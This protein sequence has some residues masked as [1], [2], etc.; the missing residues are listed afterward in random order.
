MAKHRGESMTCKEAMKT[1]D[2]IPRPKV[3]VGI[4]YD[5]IG[6]G[7]TFF[8]ACVNGTV[9]YSSEDRNKADAAARRLRHALGMKGGEG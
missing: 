1:Y 2:L 9:I 8:L 3:T 7:P 5:P 4:D 6:M